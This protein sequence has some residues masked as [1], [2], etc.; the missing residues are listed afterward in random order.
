MEF[1][2]VLQILGS[3][4]GK[5]GFKTRDIPPSVIRRSITESEKF[6]EDS[7][8]LSEV[9]TKLISNELRRLYV[10]GF[11]KR[12]RI[13]RECETKSGKTC[14]RGYEY[15]YTISR[16]GWKYLEFLNNPE[17]QDNE[18]FVSS[19]DRISLYIM[20]KIFPEDAWLLAW[21]VGKTVA[22]NP[23]LENALAIG[24]QLELMKGLPRARWETAWDLW[25]VTN[26]KGSKRRFSKGEGIDKALMKGA[27][28]KLKKKNE[29]LQ[30][31][32]EELS[33]EKTRFIERNK[34]LV[35]GS[36]KMGEYLQALL[37]RPF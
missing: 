31:V 20:T 36:K 4:F 28:R 24:M 1:R 22:E 2:Q 32:I 17:R 10:M 27:I 26:L 12:E 33:E 19:A 11:L 35:A 5:Q 8:M 16:Q 18:S 7:T 13:K 23:D 21:D 34:R 3:H 30:K 37:R 14:F 9:S 15:V 25:K 6:K 29:E